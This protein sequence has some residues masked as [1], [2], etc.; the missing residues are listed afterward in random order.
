MSNPSISSTDGARSFDT[1]PEHRIRLVKNE[2]I[3]STTPAKDNSYCKSDCH[4]LRTDRS[5]III[6]HI[7]R[8]IAKR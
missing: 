2:V 1:F 5:N 6:P 8:R 7:S 4:Y 3:V